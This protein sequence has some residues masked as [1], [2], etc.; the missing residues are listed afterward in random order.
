M[1]F[2]PIRLA[3]FNAAVTG[4][5]LE[6]IERSLRK[7]KL[8]VDSNVV[9]DPVRYYTH[10]HPDWRDADTS[11]DRSVAWEAAREEPAVKLGR[12]P[13]AVRPRVAPSPPSPG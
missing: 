4:T 9:K 7:L 3:E 6:Q 13:A 8:Q 2:V 12:A 10:R 1:S 5:E 11:G